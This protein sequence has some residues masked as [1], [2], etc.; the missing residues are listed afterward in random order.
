MR[1]T[2]RTPKEDWAPRFLE[3][4][5]STGIVR[6]AA[7]AAGIGRTTAYERRQADP[8]FARAWEQAEHDATDALEAEARRR[9]LN[10]SDTLLI[11]LLKANRP[12]KFRERVDVRVQRAELEAE[13]R[14]LAESA[15]VDY[16]AALAE[17][18]RILTEAKA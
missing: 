16:A 7:M 17:A 12:D 3:A 5:R 13:V 10:T 14:R 18:E 6:L 9:V 2:P 8:A 11:F 1:R 15:G 4:Y